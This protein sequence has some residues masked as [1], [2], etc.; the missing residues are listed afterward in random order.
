M[1]KIKVKNIM[2][3]VIHLSSIINIQIVYENNWN[4]AINKLR[5]E[6]CVGYQ[7]SFRPFIK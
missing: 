2:Y 7:L 3:I 4:L 5:M 6:A 1:L